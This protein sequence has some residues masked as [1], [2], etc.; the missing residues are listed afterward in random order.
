LLAE[1]GW[2]RNQSPGQTKPFFACREFILKRTPL[3][4][5]NSRLW[6]FAMKKALK[7]FSIVFSVMAVRLMTV[8]YAG[9]QFKLLS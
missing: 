6:G 9:C 2:R 4:I 7:V 8:A 3:T 5:P 1:Q